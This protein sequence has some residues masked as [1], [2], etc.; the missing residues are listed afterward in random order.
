MANGDIRTGDPARDAHS[1]LNMVLLYIHELLLAGRP[2]DE[3]S[4]TAAYV[5]DFCS[6][7]LRPTKGHS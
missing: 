3:V 7:G 2:E 6:G 4:A 1:I 5:W